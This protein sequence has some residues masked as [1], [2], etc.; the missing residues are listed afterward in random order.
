VEVEQAKQYAL[1]RLE[2]ELSPNLSY[3]SIQH[4]RDD[5]VPAVERLAG[6]EAVTGE[7]LS[8]VLTAAWFHD[9]GYLEQR[10]YHELISARIAV[11][12]LPGYGYTDEQVEIVRW[13]ILATALPQAPQNLI[14]QILTDADLDVLGREDLIPRNDDLR[15]ELLSFGQEFTELEWCQSQ[16]R[17]LE[18]HTYFTSSARALRDVGKMKN[19][20]ELT[21]RLKAFE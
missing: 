14:E 9:L 15:R 10:Q 3:H 1:R 4:T 19:F 13:A 2:K 17:F 20:N 16:I 8:L 21:E 6:M 12:V 5:V 18:A 11:K 7:S